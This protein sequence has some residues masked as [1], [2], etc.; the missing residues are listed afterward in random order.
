MPLSIFWKLE[1]KIGEIRSIP[2]SLQLEDQTTIIP[3]GIVED[4]LVWVDKFV[5]RVDF[6]V[7]NMEEDREVPLILG[8]PFLATGRSILDIQE[9]QLKLR[10][11]KKGWFSRWRDQREHLKTS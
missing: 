9:M 2:V 8:R 10:L 7:V 11:G 5:F 1:G 6:L 4:M 3:E